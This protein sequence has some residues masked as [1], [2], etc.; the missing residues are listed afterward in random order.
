ML[1][2]ALYYR[3]P[4][5]VRILCIYTINSDDTFEHFTMLFAFYATHRVSLLVRM[6][7]FPICL[8]TIAKGVERMD[9]KM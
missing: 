1:Q 3:V 6:S 8:V 4:Y 2:S 5:S 9:F 7:P